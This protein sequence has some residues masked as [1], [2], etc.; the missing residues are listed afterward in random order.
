MRISS[1]YLLFLLLPLSAVAQSA[2]DR[3]ADGLLT[4]PDL[5]RIVDLQ[6]ER[7]TATLTAL[8]TDEDEAVRAR[9]AFALAS[10]QDSTATPALLA[11]LDDTLASVR[12]DA[13]FALGQ[14][15]GMVPSDALFEALLGETDNVVE[16]RLLEALGKTGSQQ[17]LGQLATFNLPGMPD[18]QVALAIGRFGIRD[19]HT[20]EATALLSHWIRSGNAQ[21][22][23]NA[24]YYF[25]RA[26]QTNAWF[27]IADT[28]RAVLDGLALDDP[29]AMHLARGLG[30]L[31]DETDTPRLIRWLSEAADWRIRN[32]AAG[33]LAA[34]AD[35]P[36]IAAALFKAL[37]DSSEHVSITAAN[38]LARAEM[39][40]DSLQTLIRAWIEAHPARWRITAPLLHGPLRD[41]PFVLRQVEELK[42]G[43]PV[44]YA[45]ALP[46][47]TH[48]T[49][50]D[51]FERLAEEAVNENIR[52]A[53]TALSALATRWNTD[54]TD[55]LLTRPYF[56][57]FE[58]GLNRGDLTLTYAV[59]PALSDSLFRPFGAVNALATVYRTLKAPT[60]VDAMI[61][62]LSALGASGDTSAEPILRE[63]LLHPH[64]FVSRA[65]T[66]ALS[67]LTGEDMPPTGR[68]IPPERTA[69]WSYLSW[70]GTHPHLILETNKGN[71]TIELDTEQAPLTT[72]TLLQFA[73]QGLYDGVPFH[74]VVPNFVVQ[75]G[76]FA[77]RDGFG[78]PDFSIRS[79]FT[80]LPYRTGTVGMASSGKDTEGSQYFVTHS[81]Q[82]HLDGRYTAFG[83]I[84]NGLE[85]VDQIYENDRV[86]GVTVVPGGRQVE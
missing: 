47:L 32:N 59:A 79:E 42:S 6:I 58:R 68:S 1:I 34:H 2:T 31:G 23:E 4:R 48:L 20:P 56:E 38:T 49:D 62:I 84:V 57:I 85:V 26:S 67:T 51:A 8:L 65:A 19:V 9:A 28:I 43:D 70:K 53:Y 52:V 27:L 74:R 80:R 13:A 75:G 29:A 17:A 37:G 39:W 18:A 21:V 10:V 81:M 14:M 40:P 35:H 36:A 11:L 72:Q 82:P 71:I 33:A 24:A 45:R 73:E 22:R 54:R 55:P 86:L 25:G 64:P 30:R 76:D 41:G 3:P 77:R 60:D 69:D 46:A 50:Q 7:D 63:S 16:A 44:G 5:Q 61:A 83:S 12:A 78:G 15:P 66:R